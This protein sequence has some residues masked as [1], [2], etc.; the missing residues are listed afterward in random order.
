MGHVMETKASVSYPL[1]A[2]SH[3]HAQIRPENIFQEEWP[4]EW[5]KEWPTEWPKEWPKAK[6]WPK[7]T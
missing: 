2:T 5:P 7:G 1:L 6:E 4:K 3:Q